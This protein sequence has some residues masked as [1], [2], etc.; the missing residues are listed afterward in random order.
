MSLYFL[1]GSK[2]SERR[3]QGSNKARFAK[4]E[5]QRVEALTLA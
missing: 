1:P 2:V 5:L 4:H 3:K